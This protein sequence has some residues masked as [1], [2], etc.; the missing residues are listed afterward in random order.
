MT[1]PGSGVG[2]DMAEQ[3]AVVADLFGRRAAI[4]T[5]IWGRWLLPR[6]GIVLVA[7]GSSDHAAIYARYL[8]ELV[9]AVPVVL[10]AP[11]LHTRYRSRA[12]YEGWTAIAISQS[13]TTPEIATT[14]DDLAARGARTIAVTN[15]PESPLAATADL[16]LPLGCGPDRARPATKTF[17]A[18]LAAVAVLARAIAPDAWTD[19]DEHRLVEIL[20]ELLADQPP[21]EPFADVLLGATGATH[22][23]RG[24]TLPAALEGALE[25]REMTGCLAEG[26][27]A[28][29][30]L[31]GPIAAT[32]EQSAVVA[33]VDDGPT[34]TDVREAAAAAEARGAQV[35]VVASEG[36]GGTEALAVPRLACE[37]LAAMVHAVRAQQLAL[38]CALRAG[39][40][41]DRPSGPHHVTPRR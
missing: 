8:L 4:G 12:R 3:P 38:A 18:S 40:D 9:A 26:I 27:A 29:E 28:V 24:F 13:E 32:G 17:L 5:A 16:A 41:P 36:R 6:R 23:G 30:Y 19:R 15:D 7:R 31:H 1:G 10:A 14:L 11:S 39:V 25:L 21:L 37:P 22:L 35:L 33:Y 34:A 20:T 2:K